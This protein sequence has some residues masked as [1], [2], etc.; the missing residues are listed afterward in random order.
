MNAETK[1]RLTLQLIGWQV[2]LKARLKKIEGRPALELLL[3]DSIRH[4][5]Q[6]TNELLRELE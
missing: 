6:E 5:L 4:D 3:G 2:E 1:A